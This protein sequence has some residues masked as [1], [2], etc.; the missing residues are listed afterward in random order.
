MYKRFLKVIKLYLYTLIATQV[1]AVFIIRPLLF[2]EVQ[3]DI[4]F[5][6]FFSLPLNAVFTWFLIKTGINKL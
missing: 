2:G 4:W 6:I 1:L 3:F 5:F